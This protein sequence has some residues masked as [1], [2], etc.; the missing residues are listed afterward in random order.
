M[1]VRGPGEFER[2]KPEGFAGVTSFLGANSDGRL[3][4]SPGATSCHEGWSSRSAPG[5]TSSA[6]HVEQ[7]QDEK[8]DHG[9]DERDHH[10]A[11]DRVPDDRDAPVEDAG[12]KTAEQGTNDA[13]DHVTHDS[14]AVAQREVA[15]Q[16]AG[17][18]ADENPHQDRVEIEVENHMYQ[19]L[20]ADKTR[21]SWQPTQAC[22]AM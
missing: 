11:Q 4:S 22:I 13:R 18:Q 7:A 20:L 15:G 6:A 16:K 3:E 10:L 12:E 2:R 17:H 21:E 8:D 9:T 5:R 1:I 14:K 19:Y